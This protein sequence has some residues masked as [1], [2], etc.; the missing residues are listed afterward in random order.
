MRS[1]GLGNVLELL[2]AEAPGNEAV[3]CDR[4][5]GRGGDGQEG[6][7]RDYLLFLILKKY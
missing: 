3:T 4:G 7:M 5:W 1:W 6:V 2:E